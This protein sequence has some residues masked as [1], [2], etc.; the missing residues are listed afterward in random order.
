MVPSDMLFA[1][2]TSITSSKLG[3]IECETVRCTML[4]KPS[5]VIILEGRKWED[6]DINIW[7]KILQSFDLFQLIYVIPQVCRAW[8]SACSDQLLWKTLDL[9]VLL[10]NFIRISRKP[11]VYVNSTSQRKS[12]RLLNICLNLSCGNI[13]TLIYHHYLYVKDNQL[14]FTAKRYSFNELS[15]LYTDLLFFRYPRLKH[16]V[17]PSW[18]KIKKKNPAYVIARSCKKLS[19]LKIISPCDMLFA[20]A[21]V[22]FLPNLKLLEGLK[23]LKVFNLSHFRLEKLL[24]LISDSCIKCQRTLNDEGMIRWSKYEEDLWKVDEVGSLA[25]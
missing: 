7:V 24:T 3:S 4:S 21:L 13:Q 16:L 12:I 11:Y 5:L 9:S 8:Q 2:Y 25:I 20:S 18:N 22:S 15:S 23:K 6:L 1:F 17:M 14:T 19:E 10:S